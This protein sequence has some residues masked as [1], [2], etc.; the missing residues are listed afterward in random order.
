MKFIQPPGRYIVLALCVLG[1]MLGAG[2]IFTLDMAPAPPFPDWLQKMG[3][4]AILVASGIGAER[5]VTA[6][7]PE[8]ATTAAWQ[9]AACF[10]GILYTINPFVYSRFMAG[11]YRVLLGYALLP[12]FAAAFVTLM[13]EPGWRKALLASIWLVAISIV[14]IHTVGLAVLVALVFGVLWFWRHRANTVWRKKAGWSVVMLGGAMLLANSYWLLPALLGHGSTAE[15]V[16]G[17][18]S[19]DLAAFATNADGF[20][21]LGNVLALQGFWADTKSLYI[22]PMDVYSWWW[23]P[24][25]GLWLLV[26][27]GVYKSWKVQRGLAI[28]LVAL[29]FIAALLAIG[30]AG[31]LAK[32]INEFL[33]HYIPFFAGYREPQKFVALIAL[34]YAYFGAVAVAALAQWAQ[35]H[36]HNQK[37]APFVVLPVFA[38]PF[39]AAPLMLWGF[40]GQLQPGLYPAEWYSVNDYLQRVDPQAKVLFLPWHMYMRFDFAGRVIANPADRFFANPIIISS[41]PEMAGAKSYTSNSDQQ[42]LQSSILPA[43]LAGDKNVAKNLRMLNIRYVIVAKELDY[44]RY[45]FLGTQP[46][47][48][49]VQETASVTVY[50]VNDSE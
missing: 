4:I 2:Y 44:K 16:A 37:R 11:Q 24:W 46:G 39:L 6:L 10:A 49:L 47:F 32:P 18:G 38:L 1:P 31:T 17:F 42:A 35:G 30:T 9:W 36:A 29:I 13:R 22:V 23:A 34:A 48:S 26:L 40:N 20:G 7:K 5:F 21:W 12:F 41:D 33:I 28:A 25:L 15:A 19:A 8:K 50:K 14:S 3:L 43:A 45:G 27:F